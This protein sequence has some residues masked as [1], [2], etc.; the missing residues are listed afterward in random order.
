[1]IKKG[2]PIAGG[3]IS[4]DLGLGFWEGIPTAAVMPK[5]VG[6]RPVPSERFFSHAHRSTAIK[7]CGC[8]CP[9]P[10]TRKTPRLSPKKNTLMSPSLASLNDLFCRY[11]PAL[12]RCCR[13]HLRGTLEDAEDVVHS[14]YLRCRRHWS[15][16]RCSAAHAATYFYRA[17]RWEMAD[18]ARRQHRRRTRQSAPAGRQPDPPGI[19]LRHL[20]VREALATLRGRQLAICLAYMAGKNREAICRELR[21][22]PGALAVATCRAKAHLR[23]VLDLSSHVEPHRRNA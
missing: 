7:D 15:A 22:T 21:L 17:L 8:G 19:L 5:T 18:S 1:M 9:T 3:R 16:D 23:A 6:N 4:K 13:K 12:I 11:Y 10:G 20:V 14:A 2:A